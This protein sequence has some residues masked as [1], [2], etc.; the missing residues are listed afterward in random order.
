MEPVSRQLSAT[1]A[2]RRELSHAHAECVR[3]KSSYE[4]ELARADN[5]QREV[6]AARQGSN[7]SKQQADKQAREIS[8]LRAEKQSAV[9]AARSAEEYTRKLEAK[10]T[11]GSKGQFLVEQNT[12]LRAALQQLKAEHEAAVGSLEAHK[13]ELQRATREIE[14][15]ATA[16]E[17]RADELH[18]DGDLKSGLLYEVAHRREES[19]RMEGEAKTAKDAAAAAEFELRETKIALQRAQADISALSSRVSTLSGE[20]D[21]ER[22]AA[23]AAQKVSCSRRAQQHSCVRLQLR[24]AR[25]ALF[26]LLSLPT[27]TTVVFPLIP[28]SAAYCHT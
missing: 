2:L 12:K 19:R 21:S 16:L 10:L 24:T 17:M 18:L 3:Y 13:V 14:V 20:L 15:L 25:V 8:I 5:L 11:M 28:T 9:E 7:S 26:T 6:I 1:E 4:K 22:N 27:L 23:A